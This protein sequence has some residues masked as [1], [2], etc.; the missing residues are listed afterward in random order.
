MASG[1]GFGRGRADRFGA[2]HRKHKHINQV[3]AM[4]LFYIEQPFSFCKFVDLF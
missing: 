2:L 4:R 1:M 3:V